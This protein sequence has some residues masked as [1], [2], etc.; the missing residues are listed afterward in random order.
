[1][2]SFSACSWADV[3]AELPVPRLSHEELQS[4]TVRPRRTCISVDQSE[5]RARPTVWC[6]QWSVTVLDC[7]GASS[8]LRL[9]QLLQAKLARW[10]NLLDGAISSTPAL[11]QESGFKRTVFLG[12]LEG[13]GENRAAVLGKLMR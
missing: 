6:G 5:A 1:M 11:D 4:Q 8:V 12:S 7:Q 9:W 3:R 2:V 10:Q 13:L